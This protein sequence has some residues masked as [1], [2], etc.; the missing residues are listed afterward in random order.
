[1]TKTF[2]NT[3]SADSPRPVARFAVPSAP[4]AAQAHPWTGSPVVFFPIYPPSA[5][6][7]FLLSCSMR[8][9]LIPLVLVIWLF[10]FFL[11]YSEKKETKP[12]IEK[13][14]IPRALHQTWYRANNTSRP[15]FTWS[16]VTLTRPFTLYLLCYRNI[17]CASLY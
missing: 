13:E 10:F 17:L 16:T 3:H 2:Y 4:L 9:H 14:L 11:M 12:T 5:T 7:I 8:L 1:M 15:S 6:S